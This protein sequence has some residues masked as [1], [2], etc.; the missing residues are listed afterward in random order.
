MCRISHINRRILQEAGFVTRLKN[1][2]V[3]ITHC[4]GEEAACLEL[5]QSHGAGV[6]PEEQDEGHQGD[7]RHIVTGL[8]QQLASE[9]QTLLLGQ[10]GPRGILLLQRQNG[11]F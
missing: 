7:V 6:G 8:F 3:A 4:G 9:P 11:P 10:G 5:L 1:K 2:Q